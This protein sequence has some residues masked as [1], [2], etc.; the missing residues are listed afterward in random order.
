VLSDFGDTIVVAAYDAELKELWRRTEARKKDHLGHYIYPVDLTGDG[1]DEV[2]VG[3]LVLDARGRELWNRFDLFYDNHDHA[4]SYRFPD[5]DGDGRPEIVS[6]QSEAGVFAFDARTGA[7]R[8][9]HAGEHSQQ[10]E[11]GRFLDGVPGAQVVVGARTYGNRAAGEPYL[12]AQ[13]LW[14]DARGTRRARWPAA[15]L[16]G[17]PVFVAGDW[18]GRGASE[19]FWHKFRLGGDARGTLY[20]PDPV[21]HMFDFLGDGAEEVITLDRDRLRVY[22]FAGAN[23]S[24]R[25]VRRPDDYLRDRVANHTHY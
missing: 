10:I 3:S 16:N 23:A 6:A 14:F 5:L 13:V 24:G 20:F 18:R 19:L 4:D 15:P 2:V 8:W 1:V 22:G 25:P 21:Y 7:V 9:Q 11:V 12:S 17:N